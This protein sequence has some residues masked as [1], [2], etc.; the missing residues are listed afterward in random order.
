VTRVLERHGYA[1]KSDN[2]HLRLVPLD[3]NV[4]LDTVTVMK[5]PSEY[6]GLKNLRKQIEAAI[7]LNALGK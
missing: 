5:T 6:R 3:S 1:R 4:G 2:K 7:G